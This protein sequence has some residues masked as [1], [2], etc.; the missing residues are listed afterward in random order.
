MLL[1]LLE[2][3]MKFSDTPSCDGM[4]INL[5]FVENRGDDYESLDYVR[6]MCKNCPVLEEC[7][8]YALTYNVKGIWAGTT[9]Q[10]RRQIRVTNKIPVKPIYEPR[11]YGLPI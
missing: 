8:K 6:K 5:F 1:K 2:E 4:D 9:E 11:E 10:Q 7:F 3:K